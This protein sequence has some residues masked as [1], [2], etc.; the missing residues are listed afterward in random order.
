MTSPFKGCKL[1]NLTQGFKLKDHEA[2]DWYST[3]GTPLVAPFNC[4]IVNIVT[5]TNIESTGAEL[6]RGYGVRIQSTEDPIIS[7]TMWHCMP[8]FPVS[9][10]DAVFQGGV[11]AFMGNSG[12]VLSGGEIV[13]IDIRT[14]PPYKGTHAHISLGQNNA[15]GTYTPLDYSQ[16]IDFLIP[17]NYDLKSA[18]QSTLF[19]I[20]QFLAH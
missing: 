7:M 3:Y 1:N 14:V 18:I 17:I 6:S 4:K 13:P 8:F 16:Y 19:K 10:G 11:I 2:N 12:F 5:T 20:G 9:I 15:D